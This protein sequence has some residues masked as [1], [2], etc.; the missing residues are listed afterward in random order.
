MMPLRLAAES[1][2]KEIVSLLLDRGAD[3]EAKDRVGLLVCFLVRV[4][5]V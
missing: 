1:G 4:R 5:I 2:H 3:I